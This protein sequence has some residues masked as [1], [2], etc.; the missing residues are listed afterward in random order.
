MAMHVPKA[1]GVAQMLKDGARVSDISFHNYRVHAINR[2]AIPLTTLAP[3][4]GYTRK[5]SARVLAFYGYFRNLECSRIFDTQRAKRYLCLVLFQKIKLNKILRMNYFCMGV[6][7]CVY[8]VKAFEN[9]YKF[10]MHRKMKILTFCPVMSCFRKLNLN[11]IL[12]IGYLSVTSTFFICIRIVKMENLI[13]LHIKS[14]WQLDFDK[15]VIL[16][17]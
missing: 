12:R 1:P 7:V 10:Y 4:E 11:K 14:A 6:Y 17:F 9:L 15:F 13:F 5:G 16:C 3:G 8:V 2:L